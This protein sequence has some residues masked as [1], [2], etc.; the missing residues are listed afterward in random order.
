MMASDNGAGEKIKIGS[1]V[2]IVDLATGE[3]LDLK[4]VTAIQP[5]ERLEEVSLA[6]LYWDRIT[7]GS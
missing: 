5:G 1:R 7:G 3:L 2:S 4:V 6:R